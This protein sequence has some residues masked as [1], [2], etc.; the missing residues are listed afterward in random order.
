MTWSTQS[1]AFSRSQ[2]I[3]PI[4]NFLFM[5]FKISFHNLKIALSVEELGLKPNWSLDKMLL[6]VKWS[7][8]LTNIS[9]SKILEKEG[10]IETGL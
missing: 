3:P 6:L 4:L 2:N 9:F 1:K 5:T 8:S 10:N 7:I